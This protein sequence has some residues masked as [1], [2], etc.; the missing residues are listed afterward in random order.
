MPDISWN[1]FDRLSFAGTDLQELSTSLSRLHNG[2][3]VKSESQRNTQYQIN[4]VHTRGISIIASR[5]DGD[6]S[7][8]FPASID[9]SMVLIP[10]TGNAVVA[11]NGRQLPSIRSHGVFVDRL[12]KNQ[13]RIA[14]PRTHL[15]I[16][17]PHF[18]LVRRVQARLDVSLRGRLQFASEV[19]LS[20]GPGLLLAR[21]AMT[22]HHGLAGETLH[23]SPVVL[24][25]LLEAMLETLI[26]A[27]PHN[28]SQEFS[29]NSQSPIPRHVKR[30]IHYMHAN[31][32]R[33]V[34]LKEIA[35]AC[36]V[37]TRT[38]Q[39]G[40]RRFRMT[41]PM[42]YMEHL[43]LD[44]VREEL[45]SADPDQSVRAIAQKWGFIHVG[46]FSGQ[47]RRRFGELPSQT[48]RRIEDN[49][50]DAGRADTNSSQ[51]MVFAE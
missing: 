7:M 9:T 31:I 16:R 25:H 38:L 10:L 41:T 1:T 35:E 40:F 49:P 32:S 47:Y 39:D 11:V 48:L 12:L 3:D 6:F 33:S 50:A 4:M 29:R 45:A 24:G 17:V 46:R 34:A 30:A 51:P 42:T 19:D 28:H 37:S 20:Q 2:I 22:M 43:R 27:I 13:L 18:E 36:G 23:K 5:Y 21:I 15:C 26:D 14:G 44:A 8:H